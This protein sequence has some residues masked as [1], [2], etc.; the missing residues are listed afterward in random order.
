MPRVRPVLLGLTIPCGLH[1]ADVVTLPHLFCFTSLQ[2]PSCLI[3]QMPRFGKDFKM[4][5]KI[6]PSLELDITD[7]LEDS[8]WDL[9]YCGSCDL[10]VSFI[11][12]AP[13]GVAAALDCWFNNAVLSSAAPRECRIC[14]GLALYECRD[15][16]EDGDITAGK[17]KQFCEKCNIQVNKGGHSSP[18]T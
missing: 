15:C 5:N 1:T 14:G 13:R 17:I 7:L 18:F 4:F 10:N 9:R 6:F 8:E 12:E 2:A 11:N 16:Y 3:I